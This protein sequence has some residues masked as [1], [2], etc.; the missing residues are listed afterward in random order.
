MSSLLQNCAL[1]N[2]YLL[3]KKILHWRQQT[4]LFHVHEWWAMLNLKMS[5]NQPL[6]RRH[7]ISWLESHFYYFFLILSLCPFPIPLPFSMRKYPCGTTAFIPLLPFL[8]LRALRSPRFGEKKYT[9]RLFI[10]SALS[11]LFLVCRASRKLFVPG[12]S[13]SDF[14][15]GLCWTSLIHTLTALLEV[16]ALAALPS[17][18]LWVLS[19]W[20]QELEVISAFHDSCCRAATSVK[21]SVSLVKIYTRHPDTVQIKFLQASSFPLYS[22]VCIFFCFP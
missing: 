14:T 19:C 21:N 13:P 9:N 15:R 1:E 17:N 4:L 2:I 20:S 16:S 6:I 3:G 12:D 10:H 7:Y 22:E 5:V 18:T 8:H 11:C